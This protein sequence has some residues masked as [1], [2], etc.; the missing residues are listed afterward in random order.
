MY[1]KAAEGVIIDFGGDRFLLCS[2]WDWDWDSNRTHQLGV[3][4]LMVQ[5]LQVHCE[6]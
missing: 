2:H 6:N 5:R 4:L 3:A 1:T